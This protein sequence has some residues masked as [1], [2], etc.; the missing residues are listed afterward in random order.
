MHRFTD[1]ILGRARNS[2]LARN[3]NP[4]ATSARPLLIHTQGH[5]IKHAACK[6][7]GLSLLIAMPGLVVGCQTVNRPESFNASTNPNI[8]HTAEVYDTPPA[9]TIVSPEINGPDN[10][11]FIQVAE[12][13][14][15]I[16]QVAAKDVPGSTLAYRLQD[17]EDK[18]QFVLDENTGTLR[19]KEAPDWENP[20]DADANNN[21]MLLWQVINSTGDA[22][23]QFVVIQVTDL[24]EDL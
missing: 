3:A 11:A 18:D 2:N 13:S 15:N 7:I 10:S 21:Y 20:T 8:V 17:G 6:W 14:V 16:T 24:P 23:S 1:T 22:R 9:L 12:N 5:T 19:F 4:S